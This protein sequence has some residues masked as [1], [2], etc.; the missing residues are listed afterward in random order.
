[1]N[2]NQTSLIVQ[3]HQRAIALFPQAVMGF[4][5]FLLLF[6]T[7]TIVFVLIRKL[8]NNLDNDKRDIIYLI[9]RILYITI[10]IS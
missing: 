7:A 1:M 10:L 3:V 4:G 5:I 8:A 2:T 9:A 6:L